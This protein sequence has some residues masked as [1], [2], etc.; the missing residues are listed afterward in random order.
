MASGEAGPQS[1]VDLMVVGDVDDMEL[2]GAICE[3]EKVLGRTV[4]YTLIGARE[5]KKRRGEEGE[6]I[7][8]VLSGP[9]LAVLGDADEIR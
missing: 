2:H 9:R 4:N 5:F 1:D 6:F 8:R 7:S 3:A